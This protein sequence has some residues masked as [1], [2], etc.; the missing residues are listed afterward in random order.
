MSVSEISVSTADGG[1]FSAYLAKAARPNGAVVV[2]LQEIFGVNANIRGIA[3]ELAQ[4]GYIAVAPDLFWRLEPGLQ[5]NPGSP[6]DRERAMAL[7]QKI[8]EKLAVADILATINA[9]KALPEATGKTGVVGYCFGGKLAFL[10]SAAPQV[11]AAISYYGTGIQQKL[12]IAPEIKA[13]LLLH[14]ARADHLCPPEAQTQIET[15]LAPYA[16][17]VSVMFYEGAGHAFARKGAAS[18]DATAAARADHATHALLAQI[19]N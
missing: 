18:F 14:V 1:K 2:V 16:D 4:L 19:L 3:D 11:D 10:L 9:T 6:E 7:M 15:T 12:G 5:L 17:H 8:D 13:R